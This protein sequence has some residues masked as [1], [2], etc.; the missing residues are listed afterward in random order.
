MVKSFAVQPRTIIE[1][2]AEKAQREL[3]CFIIGF[4]LIFDV[5]SLKAGKAIIFL[6]AIK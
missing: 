4:K 3:V 5:E 1:F 2:I 6:K